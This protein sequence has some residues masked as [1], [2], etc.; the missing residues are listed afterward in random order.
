MAVDLQVVFPQEAIILN[1]VR[2][3]PGPPRV[4][5]VTGADFRAVDEVL[6]N[7]VAS[8]DYVV[9]SKT[10]LAAQVPDSLS[11]QHIFTVQVLSRRLTITPRSLLRFRIGQKPGKV[12]GIQRL[13]QKFLRI[14]FTTPGTDIFNKSLGGGGLVKVGQTFGMEDGSDILSNLIIAIDTTSRQLVALQSRN[15]SL[16]P[17]ERLLSAKVLS[18]G[19]DKAEGAIDVVVEIV[20]QAGRAA[21]ANLEL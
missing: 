6:I 21:V 18:A 1:N 17:D 19:F 4:V 13:L 5:D 7:K 16:P 20:S 9:L 12:T 11:E 8:P 10:R 14:L 2:I 15:P 3:L